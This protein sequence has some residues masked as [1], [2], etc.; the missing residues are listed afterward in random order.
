GSD[1]VR[2]NSPKAGPS[3]NL[4]AHVQVSYAPD[5]R[6]LSEFTTA[7]LNYLMQKHRDLNLVQSDATNL[8][9]NIPAH[10]L[11][12]M[13]TEAKTGTT[14]AMEVYTITNGKRHTL[15]YYAE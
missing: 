10:M 13:Y 8:T 11:V 6:T 9:S 15:T 2:F 4:N 12:Y 1:N 3:E 14:K 7:H 5:N